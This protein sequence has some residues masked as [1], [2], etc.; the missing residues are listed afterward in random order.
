MQRIFQWLSDRPGFNIMLVLLYFILVVA[1]HKVFGTFLNAVVFKG[2]TRDQ[3]NLYVI[4]GA[5]IILLFYLIIFGKN[6]TR[7]PQRSK[8]LVLMGLNI[9]FAVLVVNLLFLINIESVH[10]PQYAVFAILIFPLIGNYTSTLIWATIGGAI[11]E[12]YQYFYLAPLDTS[13]Y[14]LNDVVTNLI[15]AVFGL[16][17]L[18]SLSIAEKTNFSLKKTTAW[19]GIGIIALAIVLTHIS[20][21]LSI[22]PNEDRRYH[23]LRE[24]PTGF[25]SMRKPEVYFHIVRPIEGLVIVL[26]LF[27]IFHRISPSTDA[28]SS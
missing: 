10:F 13:Y 26:I 2:I 20:G 23:I 12:A 7:H 22:Y 6:V 21:L 17:F 4:I 18:R 24:W 19:Y 27:V 5:T 15:G 28:R 11:D 14:D 25:W 1:P 8:L 3:Y 9:L 16:L